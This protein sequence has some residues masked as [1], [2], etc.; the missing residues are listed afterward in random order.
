VFVANGSMVQYT[1]AGDPEDFT[2]TGSGYF[3]LANSFPDLS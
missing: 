1:V 2:S 3:D